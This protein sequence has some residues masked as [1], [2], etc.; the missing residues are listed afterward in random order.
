MLDRSGGALHMMGGP[1][2]PDET[3]IYVYNIPN[4]LIS[5]R[6]WPGG[7]AR[8]G[9]Y[10]LEYF[11]SRTDKTVNTPPHFELHG[12][13]RPGQFQYH[14]PTVSWER[15][16]NGDAPIL[17][18]CEKYSVPEGSHWRLTRPGHED[19]L[20]SIPTRPALYQ[21]TAP[22]PYVRPV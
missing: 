16:F 6:I 11:D 4:S 13:A 5:I 7:M 3:D 15:A 10:C 12:F 9:Q 2:A 8:Y 22:T 19:F 14:H 1:P 21:F 18:G 20:F 17:E